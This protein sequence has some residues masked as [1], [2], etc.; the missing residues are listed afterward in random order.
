MEGHLQAPLPLKDSMRQF[1]NN[2]NAVFR[3]M[4]TT[5]NKLQ[6][7]PDKLKDCLTFMQKNI[8]SLHVEHVPEDEISDSKRRV[9]Y[10]PVFPIVHP[11]KK[12]VRLVFDSAA[13]YGGMSLNSAL[14]TGP[15]CNNHL[16]GV[17]VRFREREIAFA[18]D[19]EG[20]YY[21]FHVEPS[22][23][24][25]MRFFWFRANDPNNEL[26]PFRARVHVFGNCCRPAIAIMCLRQAAAWSAAGAA[27]C[28]TT[29]AAISY[30]NTNFYIDDGLG[31][32]N[33]IEEA[34]KILTTAREFL[35][36]YKIRLHKILSSH[37]DVLEA[38]PPS[39]R[40]EGHIE[41]F[42]EGKDQ[43]TLG[44][45]WNVAEDT[46]NVSSEDLHR[47]FTKRGVLATVNAVFDP[48]GMSAPIVLGGK[49]IQ[50]AIMT[51]KQEK[52][53]IRSHVWDEPLPQCF[54]QQWITWK[55]S[56]KELKKIT[57]STLSCASRLWW[58]QAYHNACLCR[59]ITDGDCTLHLPTI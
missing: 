46:F 31:S 11:K 20:M 22:H 56:L 15:D 23:R 24:D 21:A 17:L 19:V 34:I 38:F 4:Q 7:Q 42:Q 29:A 2:K 51:T 44:V 9:W 18:A 43:R 52:S 3:R 1:P 50:R 57:H 16:R 55:D 47:P 26:V 53:S 35:G 30:I 8:D 33:S 48:I 40:G 36:R 41:L 39:E 58:Y 54:L 37:Q 49:L 28:D 27:V 6:K 10:L 25:L 13:S 12:K 59:C 32:T 14:L 5:M 45:L